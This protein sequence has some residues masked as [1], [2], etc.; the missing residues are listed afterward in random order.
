M[1]TWNWC[2]L[3]ALMGG[4][5]GQFTETFMSLGQF[6][7][8]FCLLITC[9]NNCFLQTKQTGKVNILGFEFVFLCLRNSLF[10]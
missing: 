1:D 4:T 10:H 9:F 2:S 6:V 5:D 3:L 7:L 8:Y